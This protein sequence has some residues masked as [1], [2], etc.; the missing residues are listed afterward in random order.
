MGGKYPHL[1][2]MIDL[3]LEFE[4][5]SRFIHIDRPMEE[6]IRSLVDRSAKARGWL[7]ATPE[8]CERL[9]RALWEAKTEGLAR[10]PTN[11]KFT[12]EYGRLTDDP[13]S[14]VTSLAASLGLTVAT[15]QLAA[16]AELV[17]PK[18]TQRGS[19]PQDRP[20]GCRTA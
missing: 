11:R 20:I 8:Q 18:T 5:E 13:E 7:R 4:P 3:L 10:V 9:Q 19:K 17:R 16:A 14:V 6:S 15:R 12:I 2:F 1:C